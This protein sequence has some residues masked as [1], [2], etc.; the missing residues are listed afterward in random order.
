MRRTQGFTIVEMLIALAVIAVAFAALAYTQ[1]TSLKASTHS[2]L[3]SETKTE[4]TKVLEDQQSKVLRVDLTPSGIGG[5]SQGGAYDDDPTSSYESFWFIDYYYACP[6][7]VDPPGATGG[8]PAVRGGSRSNL[9]FDLPSECTGTVGPTS[10]QDGTVESTWTI[11]GVS[12]A[13]GEGLVDITVT[14]THSGGG[15]TVQLSDRLSC[16][17]VY[18]SPKIDAPAP[19]PVPEVSGGGR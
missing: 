10:V 16:Y 18:P 4:A 17:D 11:A 19:C 2:R 3:A 8:Q 12:G 14:S 9:R 6:S 13:D 7:A 15:P 1:I 5:N